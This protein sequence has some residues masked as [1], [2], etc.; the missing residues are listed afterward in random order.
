MII[1]DLPVAGVIS[2][3]PIDTVT[4]FALLRSSFR[5]VSYRISFSSYSFRGCRIFAVRERCILQI[6]DPV[7]AALLSDSIPR[8]S[9]A[10]ILRVS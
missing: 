4:P 7:H 10:Q 8:N 5:Y 9:D 3:L 6:L 1:V 2:R